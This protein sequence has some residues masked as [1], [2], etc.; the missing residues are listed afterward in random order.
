MSELTMHFDPTA[1]GSKAA[2]ALALGEEGRRPMPLTFEAGGIPEARPYLETATAADWF[3]GAP[4]PEG[5]LS[6]LWLYFSYFDE[7][8]R[9]SQDLETRDGSFW[10]GIAHRREPDAGN[11]GYWFR[12]VGNH[13]I[14]PALREA[15]AAILAHSNGSGFRL[16]DTW[17]PFA[18]ID[19]CE[20]ARRRPGSEE[21]RVAMEIQ[22][23]EWQLLFDHCAR[24][25]K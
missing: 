19:F 22:L 18:F 24:L 1:Y 12:R 16:T 8:H 6:G 20:S 10:H 21:E 4:S 15:A 2:A 17:D 14:F 25:A 9:I 23:A 11:S 5:A 3:P 13:S 7:S